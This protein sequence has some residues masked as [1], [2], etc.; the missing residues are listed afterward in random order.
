MENNNE[1]IDQVESAPEAPAAEQSAETTTAKKPFPWLIVAICAF[2]VV[3]AVLAIVFI[4]PGNAGDAT[5]ADYCISVVDEIGNPVAGVMIKLVDE[6]GNQRISVTEKNGNA[7]FLD[8]NISTYTVIADK[9]ATEVKILQSQFILDNN[10]TDLKIVVRDETKCRPIYGEVEDTAL[11]YNVGVGTYLIPVRDGNMTYVV[12]MATTGGSYK[13]SITSGDDTATVGYYG[14]PMFVQSTHRGDGSDGYDGKSFNLSIYDI[15]TPFVFGVKGSADVTLTVERIGDA[16]FNPQYE[17]WTVVPTEEEFKSFTTG[18][19]VPVDIADSSIDLKLGEDGYY[20]I[21][22]KMV[23]VRIKSTTK[24]LDASLSFIAGFEENFV[25][26]NIGGYVYDENGNFVAKYSYNTMIGQYAEHCD[27][28]G[29][30]PLTEEMAEALKL[31]G[32][33]AGWWKPNTVNFLFDGVPYNPEYAWL[34]LCCTEQ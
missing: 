32:E 28:N 9:A 19:L 14:I 34:F 4:T 31:H 13:V 29:V 12:F 15:A 3:A 6:S 7:V 20:Y 10:T 16:P 1:M 17:P 2:A 33:N 23:Y 18:T 25:G 26:Q 22:S 30:Y 11:A 21:G 24:Y 5:V 8:I 27:A